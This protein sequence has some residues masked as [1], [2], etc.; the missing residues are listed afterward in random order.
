MVKKVSIGLLGLGV[1]GSGVVHII[2]NHQEKLKH[3]LGVPVEVK[4]VLVRNLEKAREV[5]VNP[6][7]LTSNPDDVLNDPDINVVIEVMGG[8]DIT[9]EY[10]LQA[11]SAG[12]HVVSAYL[13]RQRRR[14]PGAFPIRA[15]LPGMRPSGQPRPLGS[16]PHVH[17]PYDR[18]QRRH[19][20]CDGGILPALS[21]GHGGVG[22]PDHFPV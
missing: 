19:R 9:K 22:S 8:V 14:P 17:G 13:R 16:P 10:I 21:T 1:V 3:Q 6:A 15:L 18:G 2:N 4:R 20:G 12:K 11:F 5:D 7:L